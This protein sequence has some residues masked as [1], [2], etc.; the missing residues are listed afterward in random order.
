MTALFFRRHL[1][2][3]RRR[4]WSVG[5]TSTTSSGR[6]DECRT[7]IVASDSD[8]FRTTQGIALVPSTSSW[9]SLLTC[10]LEEFRCPKAAFSG[11]VISL[12]YLSQMLVRTNE[13]PT[14]GRIGCTVT[15]CKCHRVACEAL[16]SDFRYCAVNNF[17]Q[18]D[19]CT[20][21]S[22]PF[23]RGWSL[24]NQVGGRKIDDAIFFP[25]VNTR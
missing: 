6:P 25:H 8:I 19:F 14:L 13:I 9:P 23:F 7:I 20:D 5:I 2:L 4:N 11:A 3:P 24:S 22:P 12:I 16:P 21:A 10:R 17:Y 15:L 18:F 1:T